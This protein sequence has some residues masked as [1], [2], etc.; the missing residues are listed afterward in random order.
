[1]NAEIGTSN[2]RQAYQIR[3]HTALCR[4]GVRGTVKGNA[5]KAGL[6]CCTSWFAL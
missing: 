4:G 3:L 6:Y 5:C 1:M 2:G